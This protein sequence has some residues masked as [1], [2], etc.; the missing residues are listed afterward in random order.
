MVIVGNFDPAIPLPPSVPIH[1]RYTISD[2]GKIAARYGVT[3][4]LIPSVWPETFSFTTHEALTSG[5]PTHAFAIGAQGEAVTKAENGFPIP[6]STQQ[7]LADILLSHVKN[8]ITK[9][10][11]VAS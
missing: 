10:W 1:G 9:T 8:H 4:W 11:A 7:D 2:L 5:L 3:D 6:Y